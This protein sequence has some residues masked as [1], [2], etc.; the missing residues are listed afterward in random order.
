MTIGMAV[1]VTVA[2]SRRAGYTRGMRP[3]DTVAARVTGTTSTP[4][5]HVATPQEAAAC[6]DM[7]RSYAETVDRTLGIVSWTHRRAE[8]LVHA[9]AAAGRLYLV[10]IDGAMA[11][12]FAILS[13]GAPR[14][15]AVQWAEVGARAAYLHRLAVVESFRAAGLGKWC[16]AQGERIATEAG[17]GYLRLDCLPTEVRAMTFYERL[18]YTNRGTITVESGDSRQPRVDLACFEKRLS[19]ARVT[20]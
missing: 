9:D 2:P 13:E 17:Y 5:L 3:T 8:E 6:Y 12:T 20:N 19:G 16:M 14:F 10:R 18:G 4:V 11:A 1:P 15:A 7:L